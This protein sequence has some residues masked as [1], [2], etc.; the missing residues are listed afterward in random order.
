MLVM[1]VK[2]LETLASEKLTIKCKQNQYEDE[3]LKRSDLSEYCLIG[4]FLQS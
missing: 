3:E 4:T 2:S 1:M